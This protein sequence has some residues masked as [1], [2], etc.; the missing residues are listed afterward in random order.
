[1]LVTC[2]QLM[3]AYSPTVPMARIQECDGRLRWWVVVIVVVARVEVVVLMVVEV[4]SRGSSR[5]SNSSRSSSWLYCRTSCVSQSQSIPIIL[6][7]DELLK[8][9][10]PKHNAKDWVSIAKEVGG[11]VVVLTVFDLLIWLF[12]LHQSSLFSTA[13]ALYSWSLQWAMQK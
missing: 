8:E 12:H 7:Q 10:V 1:M 13:V 9:A 3:A 4:G 6:L 5:S 11:I 2:S